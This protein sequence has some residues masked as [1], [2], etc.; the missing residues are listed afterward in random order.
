MMISGAYVIR[1][2]GA[3]LRNSISGS[4]YTDDFILQ[5][6][7]FINNAT[8]YNWSDIYSTLTAEVKHTLTEAVSNLAAI[9]MINYDMGGYTSRT[10]AEIMINVLKQRADECIAVLIEKKGET[11]ALGD[12]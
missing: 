12:V 1:K 10:E 3:G 4:T 6:E 8:R 5:A 2:C 11:F 9:Y 7:S